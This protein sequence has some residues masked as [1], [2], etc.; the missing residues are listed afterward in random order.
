[1]AD[2]R[3]AQMAPQNTITDGGSTATHSKVVVG[4][5][6]DW[7]LARPSRTLC[8]A[9]NTGKRQTRDTN[10]DTELVGSYE[11]LRTFEVCQRVSSNSNI[12]TIRMGTPMFCISLH[13]DF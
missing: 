9:K 5:R 6:T 2:L 4:G 3:A 13:A 7:I 8:G 1:M 10:T 11:C 12:C